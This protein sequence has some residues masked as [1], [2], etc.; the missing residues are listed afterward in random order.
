MIEL[1]P[2]SKVE[3][4]IAKL[5]QM[6]INER[7]YYYISDHFQ[8][9][10]IWSGDSVTGAKSVEPPKEFWYDGIEHIL[11][12]ERVR[13]YCGWSVAYTSGYRTPAWN[14]KWKGASDSDHL[15]AR[16]G[17]MSPKGRISIYQFAMII[18]M[19]TPLD[20][21]GVYNGWSKWVHAGNN[22]KKRLLYKWG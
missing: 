21:F 1:I 5:N 6:S 10:E 14:T 12:M 18:A 8:W 13:L 11:Y 22:D 3:S 9:Y 2:K 4:I 19:L 15:Y 7:K 16:A 20:H 17:D